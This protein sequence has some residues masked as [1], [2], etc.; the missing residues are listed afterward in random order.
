MDPVSQSGKRPRKSSSL[1][2]ST[3]S[4]PKYFLRRYKSARNEAG[5][6]AMSKRP[7]IMTIT[8]LA[9]FSGYMCECGNSLGR[10]GHRMRDH[11]ILDV[12]AIQEF[13]KHGKRHKDL[14]SEPLGT[15]RRGPK[16]VPRSAPIQVCA[17]AAR[18]VDEN[19]AR[20]GVFQN[21]RLGTK[22]G[23]SWRGMFTFRCKATS[24]A[25]K[26]WERGLLRGFFGH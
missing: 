13:T 6:N 9:F 3:E 26:N 7:S 8:V 21:G 2:S 4:A 14:P 22:T 24:N 17:L 11:K 20:N 10:V 23:K 5:T 19:L 1:A 12:I 16:Q 18:C 15:A 25:S